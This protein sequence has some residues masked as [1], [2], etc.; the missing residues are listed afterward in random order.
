MSFKNVSCN[1]TDQIN[2]VCLNNHHLLQFNFYLA[3][4]SRVLICD[5]LS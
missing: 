5:R 3:E 1:A 2:F 4:H